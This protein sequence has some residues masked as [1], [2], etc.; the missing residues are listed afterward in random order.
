MDDVQKGI[1]ER[2]SHIHPLIFARSLEKARSHVELFEI[3]SDF[4]KVYP[5][6]WCEQTR[7]WQATDDLL[8]SNI[9]V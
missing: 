8:Q 5:V 7:S 6:V 9:E 3:L 4:P 2:F 1:Q